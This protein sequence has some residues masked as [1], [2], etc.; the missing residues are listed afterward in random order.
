MRAF[1]L[2]GGA[3]YGALQAGALWALFE[4]GLTPDMLVG[5]SAGALNAAWLAAHCSLSGARLLCRI[6]QYSTPRYFPPLN[7]LHML[8]RLV[9]GRDSLISNAGLQAFIRRWAGGERRMGEF[10]RPRLYVVAARLEDGALHAFGDR[11]D[12]RLFDALMASTALP[13]LFPPWTV[14]GV[15]Y[16]DGGVISDLPLHIAIQRGATEIY[17]LEIVH[18]SGAAGAL[19]RR[20]VIAVGEHVLRLLVDHQIESQVAAIQ[21]QGRVRLHRIRLQASRDPGFW[22][23]SQAAALIADG[24]AQATAALRARPA[25]ASAWLDTLRHLLPARLHGSH[26]RR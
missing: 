9:Q 1:V 18:R 16:V 11:P 15:D 12:D 10:T 3:N 7:R 26:P 13:P 23:F 22:N 8:L 20:H 14:D 17:T 5:V 25:R 19:G 4:H 2:S 6:W 24:R 21:Q